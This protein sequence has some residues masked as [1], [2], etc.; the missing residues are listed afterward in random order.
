MKS[1]LFSRVNHTVAVYREWWCLDS[2]MRVE[3]KWL[4]SSLLSTE[5]GIV[6]ARFEIIWIEKWLY[7]WLHDLSNIIIPFGLVGIFSKWWLWHTEIW[8][9]KVNDNISVNP[10]KWWNICCLLYQEIWNVRF[11]LKPIPSDMHFSLS[12]YRLVDMIQHVFLISWGAGMGPGGHSTLGYMPCATKKTLL[13][14]PRFHWKTPIFTSIHP[15]TPMFN[16]LLVTER[17]WHIFV[18]QRPPIFAFNSQ[19]SDNFQQKIGFFENFNKF[20]EMLRNF[21]PFWPG[22]PP[23][24]MHFTERPSIFECF[25]TERPLFWRNLSPKDPYICGAWWHSYVT[26]KCECPP[27]PRDGLLHLKS[28]YPLWKI[29]E[30]CTTG[31][32]WIT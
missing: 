3:G 22:K 20:D 2:S 7:Y 32:V 23:F 11:K 19:T 21:W 15:M 12:L 25:V 26:F 30:K 6:I 29:L 13:F 10:G 1:I 31:G 5:I 28:L 8:K 27:P 17:P 4:S 16:K 14:S 24:F 18:T 9:C